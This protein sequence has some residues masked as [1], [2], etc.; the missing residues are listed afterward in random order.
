MAMVLG[1]QDKI[2]KSLF[3]GILKDRTINSMN[4]IENVFNAAGVTPEEY[5]RPEVACL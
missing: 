1:I 2:E 4:D 5:E 3:E